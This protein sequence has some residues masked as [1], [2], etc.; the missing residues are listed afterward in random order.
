[1]SDLHLDL[2]LNKLR[3]KG[4][5]GGIWGKFEHKALHDVAAMKMSLSSLLRC[6]FNKGAEQGYK[7]KHIPARCG[8]LEKQHFCLEDFDSLV[9]PV[10]EMFCE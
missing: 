3:V 10:F 2:Y 4:Y 9:K 8:S 1:M 6:L 7:G 5:F